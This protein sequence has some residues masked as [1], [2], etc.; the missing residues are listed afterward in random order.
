MP[1][2]GELEIYPD[3]IVG[4]STDLM[5]RG[6]Q[7]YAVWD[8]EQGLW[9]TN[10]V[11][12][13]RIVDRELYK[14]KDE[15]CLNRDCHITVRSMTDFSSGSWEQFKRYS[16][17]IADSYHQ[18]DNQIT[19]A[20]TEVSKKDYVSRRLPYDICSGDCKAYD[21]I[22]ST[23]YDPEERAKLEWSIGAII[24]GDAKKIQKFIVLYGDA[25]SGKSTVLD[26]IAKLFEG[27]CSTFDAKELTGNNNAFATDSFA[28]NPLVAIQTDGDLSE[29]RD[30]AKLNSIVSHENIII[31]EKF[32]ARY[33]MKTNC[34]L[35]MATN[36]PVKITDAKSGIIRRLID[37]KPSG[38]K[39][40]FNEY[41]KLVNQVQFELGAIAQH[42]LD[43]YNE[44][45]KSYY[46]SYRPLDMMFKTDPFFNFVEDHY[47]IFKSEDSTTLKQAYAMYKEYNKESGNE[48][49]L[50]MYKFRE[51]LKNYFREFYDEHRDEEGN[52]VRSYYEG[53]MFEKFEQVISSYNT[54][55][56]ESL[57]LT[58]KKSIFD[59]TH[60]D[61]PAQYAKEDGT[62]SM[63]WDKVTTTLKDIDTS[64]E[65]YVLIDKQEVVLDFDL[66]N[67]KGEKD[68]ELNLRAA[69]EYPP[70]Y[71]EFS[72]SGA[73]VHKHYIY[74]GDVNNLS[75]VVKPGIE[76]KVFTGKSALR[77]KLSKCN[78]IQIQHLQSG[79]PLKEK[80]KQVVNFEAVK[81]EDHLRNLIKKNLR[82]EIHPST[83][84]SID[85]I[86]YLLDQA[87]TS[88]MKYDL[89]NM[90]NAVTAFALKSTHQSD[91]CLKTV[92]KMKFKSDEASQPRTDENAELVFFD[93]EVFPNLFLVNYKKAGPNNPVIRMIN[94]SPGEIA[95]LMN[96]NLIGFNNRRY[97]N[98]ILYARMIGYSIRDLYELSKKII[99]DR[100]GSNVLFGE[101][102]N[103][104][105]TDIYDFSS[106]K[107]SLKKWE[108]E[109]GI[110]HQE[111]HYDWNQD[112]PESA[113]EEVAE[114][115]DNDVLAT[116]AVWNCEQIRADFLARKALADLVDGTVNDT[117]NSLTA[118]LLF[119]K[120][121]EPQSEFEY[122]NLAEPVTELKPAMEKFLRK[123]FPKMMDYWEKRGSKL[124]FFKGYKFENGKSTYKGKEVGEG[125]Y[126]ESKPGMYKRTFTFDVASMHPHS[127]MAEYLFGIF[128][129]VFYEL[130]QARVHIKHKD[131]EA[132]GKLFGGKLAKY[133][134]DKSQA[135]A[136]AGALKIAIN[137]VY[138][139]TAA[140]FKNPFRDTRNKDNIVA[141]RGAL[142]MIDLKEAV[143]AIGGKVIHIK[144]D[145]I[146]VENPS[147]EV[148]DL[149]LEMG[150]CYGY[151]F[152]IEH[153]FEK[154]CLV[155]D[156]VY[157]AKLAK[158]DPE[159]VE[160]CK[161]A[162][163]EGKPEP[164]RWTATGTQFAVPYVFKTLF[165]HEDILFEDLCETKSVTSSLHLDMNERM[166]NVEKEEADLEKAESNFKKG[167]ISEEELNDIREKLEPIISKGHDYHFVG[168]VGLFCPIKPQHGG[169]LL[170]RDNN[171]KFASA[172]GCKGYRWLEAEKVKEFGIEDAIDISYYASLVDGAAD[173]I[174]EFGDLDEFV[175]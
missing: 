101:A 49:E 57:A 27:Y 58:H 116:E 41:N 11:D 158:D 155:N 23:L 159:W 163:E 98:H 129:E 153:I 31:N 13:A 93:I 83:K 33:S 9:S 120:N 103:V 130:V 24:S 107:Q 164:T 121:R 123:H 109:L 8:E 46:N 4:P 71:T 125:G 5:I 28:N 1:K 78:D 147:Q 136:L 10:E 62:P 37:V 100:S 144:T 167:K 74:D 118:R 171:G 95:A 128:T 53:F 43:I 146:K 133:C 139:L 61:C 106:K 162:A 50:Q 166:I 35:Y 52:R 160:A 42:C 161:K 59:E 114:Y 143:E 20:N 141:K 85:Y 148:I 77:R 138:G 127:A 34:F 7:V 172:T 65:H 92:G 75:R 119:D 137:S 73:G 151:K 102:Y 90:E 63:A 91:I 17:K 94:P 79:L 86:Y 39:L 81:D 149:I 44:M 140:K 175:A 76:V 54:V 29:I 45:G 47:L 115:C 12:I 32:K 6:K 72:K 170:V 26:I 122:R 154:I 89:S 2:K 69:D 19:F 104:S 56:K 51:E 21:K 111:L 68:A 97:D 88:G 99:N 55:K 36:K 87:Y 165:S 113:W 135:K 173:T 168:K 22:M 48:H 80:G 157:I 117:T 14:Y 105:Y 38:R 145:S 150:E 174:K 25:G 126:V 70:T 18:L 156:A 112:I 82:K 124:P 15:K 3:F 110:H 40:E 169:G 96:Y 64:L 142:F 84:S 30:N 16:T 108:I 134:N 131:Y 132:A 66:K 152:E 67:E 60:Q